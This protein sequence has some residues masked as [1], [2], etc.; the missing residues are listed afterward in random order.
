MSQLPKQTESEQATQGTLEAN[1]SCFWGSNLFPLRTCRY[2]AGHV[3]TRKVPLHRPTMYGAYKR[4]IDMKIEYNIIPQRVFT[5]APWVGS[6]LIRFGKFSRVGELQLRPTV[7]VGLKFRFGKSS[8]VGELQLRAS[9]Q[10]E[11]INAHKKDHEKCQ[12][13]LSVYM[14]TTSGSNTHHHGH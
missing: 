12:R 8:R 6:A 14:Y 7:H 9:L 1:S 4:S 2:P 13:E 10:A 5:P 3:A 11:K